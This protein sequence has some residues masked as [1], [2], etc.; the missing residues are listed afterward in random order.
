MRALCVDDNLMNQ[1]ILTAML[2]RSGVAVDCA[3]SAQDCFQ[4]LDES[5][6]DIIFMDLRMPVIDGFEAIRM[7]RSR[8]DGHAKVPI[9]VVTA[10]TA[11]H[12]PGACIAAG[13][14]GLVTKPFSTEALYRLLAD[15]VMVGDDIAV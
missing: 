2:E 13:G 14:S 15:T 5:S 3:E 6:F 1:K 7:I 12:L 11:P 8:T 9:L 10:D 4:R